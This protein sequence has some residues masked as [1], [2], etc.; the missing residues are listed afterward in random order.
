ML[1]NRLEQYHNNKID[2][3]ILYLHVRVANVQKNFNVTR[4][5]AKT[6]LKRSVYGL[7]VMARAWILIAYFCLECSALYFLRQKCV[8]STQFV[9]QTFLLGYFWNFRIQ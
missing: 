3:Q 7:F 1:Y 5:V 8:S 4:V 9:V 2:A 6:V